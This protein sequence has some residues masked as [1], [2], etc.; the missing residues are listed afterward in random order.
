M[1]TRCV[2]ADVILCTRGESLF[3]RLSTSFANTY[4]SWIT[5]ISVEHVLLCLSTGITE[6]MNVQFVTFRALLCSMVYL[7]I[8]LVPFLLSLCFS[9]RVDRYS[10]VTS[11][12]SL[13]LHVCMSYNI[14]NQHT[15]TTTTTITY[16]HIISMTTQRFTCELVKTGHA[17]CILQIHAHTFFIQDMRRHTCLLMYLTLWSC[18]S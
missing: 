7:L 9:R 11:K 6:N 16:I 13:P 17:V 3:A 4:F 1:E 12:I 18:A 2:Y 15:T 10:S 14:P 8:S 5:V